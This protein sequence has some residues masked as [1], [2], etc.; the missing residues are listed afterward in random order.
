MLPKTLKP[1][2]TTITEPFD[3]PDFTYEIK[4][5]G[6]RCLA[7]LTEETRLQSR[8]GKDISFIF[9][10]LLGIHRHF[11]KADSLLDGEIIA[12]HHNRPNFGRLQKRA[13][14]RNSQHIQG[15]VNTIPVVYITFDLLYLNGEPLINKPIE[16]RRS[17]LK[18]NLQRV[19]EIVQAD[20]IENE[21]I[22]YF[23]SI[24]E[25]G[26]EGI[27]A[28]QKRS[29][30]LPG[31]R[32]ETWLKFKRKKFG[33]FIICG[34][35]TK[36]TTQGK[37]SSLILGAY[38]LNQL[39]SFGMVG[40]GFTA[41]ETDLIK[42]ELNKIAT[43]VCPFT[44][45]AFGQKNTVWTKPLAVCEVEYLELTDDGNLRHPSFKR[46]R[47]DLTPSECNFEEK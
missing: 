30:Y 41:N 5:D 24:A 7:F 32:T 10:E 9:P 36:P 40:S 17:L 11:N 19:D 16:M 28:K 21:G 18:E 4:W 2:L 3:S 29:C 6:Y 39:K 46:F 20:F 34:Y 42:N 43:P 27:I 37:L 45:T 13:H 14:L 25:L 8:N 38:Y 26:L 23:N 33:N 15:A 31:K 12:L 47:P 1:M 35:S 22:A 44:G